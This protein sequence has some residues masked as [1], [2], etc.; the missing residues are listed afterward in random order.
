MAN[1]IHTPATAGIC[2]TC[3]RRHRPR[4]A[5]A[6]PSFPLLDWLDA[7]PRPAPK[8]P[9]GARVPVIL[10]HGCLNAEGDTM[11][12]VMPPGA[13]YPRV[14]PTIGAAAAAALAMEAGR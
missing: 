6:L 11:A 8:R 2:P 9:S 10:L 5:R 12:A 13:R 3:G 1:H 7:Q 14:F 4:R